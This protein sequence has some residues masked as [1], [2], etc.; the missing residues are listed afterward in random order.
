LA[1]LAYEPVVPGY[2]G[3]D[4]NSQPSIG[5]AHDYLLVLRGA[6]R[7][8][9]TMADCWPGAPIYTLLY[10]AEGTS[11]RFED[12]PVHTSYLQRF[13]IR[14]RGFRRL[15]PFFPRAAERLPVQDHDVIVSSSSAFAHGVRPRPGAEHICY[16]HSPFRYAW[17]ERGRALEEAPAFARPLL[18]SLLNRVRDW[19]LDASRRATQYIANSEIT[20]E[21]IAE[22]WGRD[23]VVVHPP[24]DVDRFAIGEPEDFLLV[25]M[26]LV[27]HKRVD[28]AIES[29]RRA[30]R[31]IKVVGTG[32]D[33]ER[34]E[35]LHGDH[36]EFLG[37]VDDISLAALY[38]SALALVV[39]NVEEFGIAAVEAQAA[40]RPVVAVD[41]GGVRETV[42]DGET[43]VLVAADDPDAMAEALAQTD[44]TRFSPTRIA[45]HAQDFSADAFKHRLTSEVERLTGVQS[46]FRTAAAA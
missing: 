11:G 38:A 13:G 46:P 23:S 14:Q 29:A 6:E 15:L 1:Q 28:F 21:R 16:C 7:T 31:P 8:F 42:I 30:G 5:L 19:D 12:H 39:P 18:G 9:A 44:F 43:G 35:R 3:P 20:R 40:G 22:F 24:V 17:H 2:V 33:R 26:E 25:V 36:A 34:L 37:R 4:V 27:R 41:A 45:A 10:D 32:P